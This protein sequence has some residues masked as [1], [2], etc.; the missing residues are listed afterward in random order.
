[1]SQELQSLLDSLSGEQREAVTDF[2]RP[3]MI[4]AG[5]GTGKTRVLTS[6]I[7]WLVLTGKARPEEIL[8]LTFTDKAAN[9]MSERLDQA[10]PDDQRGVEVGTF[11]AL[12]DRLL[13]RH[14]LEIGLDADFSVLSSAQARLLLRESLFALPLER[15]RPRQDPL[16]YLGALA[17][18]FD[19]AKNEGVR[20]ADYLEWVRALGD[21]LD[22]HDDPA[23][24]DRY[25]RQN[26]LAQS[27]RVYQ[28]LLEARGYLDFGDQL[29]RTLDLLQ[30]SPHLLQS[31]RSRY[32]FLLVDEF[33][34]T[35]RAQF[36]LVRL[37]AG[38]GQ[39][40]TVVGDDDQAIYS[41]RGA[42]LANVLAF[43][44]T[45]PNA[46]QRVLRQNYRS[47]QAI[48][49]LAYT[50]IAHN[51]PHR[52]EVQHGLDKRLRAARTN[53]EPLGQDAVEV[54]TFAT[55][56]DEADAVAERIEEL[57]S[58]SAIDYSDCA[59]LVRNNRD[60]NIYLAALESRGIP[61]RFQGSHGLYERP[62]IRLL[63]AFA[64][65]VSNP[66]DSLSCHHLAASSLFGLGTMKLLT[67]NAFAR[68]QSISLLDALLEHRTESPTEGVR[69]EPAE[70]A[71]LVGFLE[72]LEELAGRLLEL[73]P[74]ALL[75]A[76][77]V[78]S[79]WMARLAADRSPAVVAEARN[80]AR[81]FDIA[82][83]HESLFPQDR[84]PQ[85][86]DHLEL[87]RQTGDS[88][89]TVESEH[90]SSAISILTIHGSKGLE[91]PAVFLVGLNGRR[92]PS[93][94]RED[95]L[96]FPTELQAHPSDSPEADHEAE[97][98]RLFYV[99]LTR[100]QR[101]LWLSMAFDEGS[102]RSQQVSPFLR[103]ALAGRAVD[104]R[105]QR[106]SP[107]EELLRHAAP[108]QAEE[109]LTWT[110]LPRDKPLRLSWRKL[111][112]YWTCPRKY[113]YQDVLQLSAPPSHQ[114]SY[115]QAL[116]EAV[117]SLLVL[118]MRGVKA[119][120]E[121]IQTAFRTRWKRAGYLSAEH[122]DSDLKRGLE[123]IHLFWQ[124]EQ[125][126]PTPRFVER[127]FRIHLG[128]NDWLAGRWDRVDEVAGV[129]SITDYK[130]SV[131]AGP[132]QADQRARDSKQLV[133]Y[134]MALEGMVGTRP[135]QV[136]LEFLGSEY[137]GRAQPDERD[138]GRLRGDIRRAALGIRQRDYTP[139]PGYKTCQHCA[140]STYC[141]DSAVT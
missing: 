102:K 125:S 16:S 81:F 129:W 49:D 14:A 91:F 135:K 99:A 100:A 120:L 17:R 4:V 56:S 45:F 6:R 80:L 137:V 12:C 123:A 64:K 89:P 34:D 18:H 37:L 22:Q 94:R 25:Q 78:R 68:Q 139:T 48:L 40:L 107:V 126:L 63:L 134:A 7:V 116:H 8:A 28:E 44:S 97:E 5:A 71:R 111:D 118:K 83:A 124:A 47:L 87:L 26:E 110:T 1:V 33:Q 130:T 36:E 15:Y 2:G 42:S 50:S 105:P 74:R 20:V 72:C 88:P 92:F 106:R 82:R 13:R 79:G 23:A 77:L 121:E 58:R 95:L 43:D 75:H 55:A 115:G 66:L 73:S 85:L 30:A 35:N 62:E 53:L 133:I 132:E 122:R 11:H 59:I 70:R 138:F 90:Q 51:N 101:L 9:E 109:S 114:V 39:N 21:G 69:L 113:F 3:L 41:F 140:F 31:L 117:T 93:W 24:W 119:S 86:V 131:V 54:R 141:S 52:L 104:F 98:R 84:L 108:P 103:E 128:D 32:R 61:Y 65:L 76:F 112:L 29:V 27:Y 67:L 127:D 19:K 57:I 96:E 60:A 38:N 46:H 136:A 10:L